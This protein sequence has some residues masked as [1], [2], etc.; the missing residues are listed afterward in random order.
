MQ[1]LGYGNQPIVVYK[2]SLSQSSLRKILFS[3]EAD[4]SL[5]KKI[6]EALKVF[7][8]IVLDHII[9]TEDSYFSFADDGLI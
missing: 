9:L 5:T 6:I 4:K 1:K 8:C 7:D 2:H 3:S